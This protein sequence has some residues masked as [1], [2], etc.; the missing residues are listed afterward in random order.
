MSSNNSFKFTHQLQFTIDGLSL[1]LHN[2][3]HHVIVIDP[4]INKQIFTLYI[5]NKNIVLI[6]VL[7]II[8]KKP[9]VYL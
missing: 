2:S 4:L 7:V 5:A 6:C 1:E 8:R 3:S 9:I